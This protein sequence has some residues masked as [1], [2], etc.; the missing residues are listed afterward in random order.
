[1]NL[2][3]KDGTVSRKQIV[4]LVSLTVLTQGETTVTQANAYFGSILADYH[5]LPWF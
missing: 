1:M 5:R 4:K 3:R 2:R